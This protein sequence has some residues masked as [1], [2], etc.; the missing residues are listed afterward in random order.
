MSRV[1]F[2][3]DDD[4]DS[5]SDTTTSEEEDSD[6]SLDTA[7]ALSYRQFLT[8]HSHALIGAQRAADVLRNG[9][10]STYVDRMRSSLD[11]Y[12]K[13]SELA[14]DIVGVESLRGNLS[15]DQ[16]YEVSQIR[17]HWNQYLGDKGT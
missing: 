4:V 13:V 15:R 2:E 14:R 9:S 11:G 8:M 1:Q 3:F 5:E 12:A 17:Q 7:D 10:S 16:L 6:G